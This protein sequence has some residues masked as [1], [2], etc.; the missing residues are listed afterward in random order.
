[1]PPESPPPLPPAAFSAVLA[2]MA[3]A[4]IVADAAERITY[5]NDAARRLHGGVDGLGV[6]VEAA[7]AV[8]GVRTMDG[9]PYAPAEFPLARAIRGEAVV[10]AR[11]R[12]RRADGSEVVAQGSATPLQGT[13][14]EPAGAV[15]V[16]R[17][18]TAEH[19]ARAAADAASRAKSQFLA[20]TSHEIRTP[21]NAIIGYSE[22]LELGIPGPLTDEQ[23]AYLERV[24]LSSRHLLGV[25]NQVLDLSK[26]EAGR[27]VI[28]V[29]PA[30]AGE[31]A[32]AAAA[33]VAPQAQAGRVALTNA[34]AADAAIAFLGDAGRVEQI[35]VN[36]LTNAVKFTEPGGTVTVTCGQT[37]VPAA[38]AVVEPHDRGWMYYRVEDTGVGIPPDQLETVFEPFVQADQGHTRTR[39]GTGL[40]L[41]ISRRLARMMGG[42][43]TARSTPAGGST[44]FVWLPAA[45]PEEVA[46][47]AAPAGERRGRSRY[48]RGLSVVG[49]AA[50]E[51]IERVLSG[52]AARL[53]S[54][55]ATPSARA[56]DDVD[57]EDHTATFLA[58][59]AQALAAIEAA[60]GEPSANLRDGTLIQR[61][62]AERHGSQRARLGWSEAE[63]RREFEVLRE[64]LAHAVRRRVRDADGV[65]LEEALGLFARF[66]A[67][68]EAASRRTM[69]V[70]AI[71]PSAAPEA[72]P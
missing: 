62:I 5:V 1:M 68:A 29:R 44:F 36:L 49:E 55:P 10:D 11:W 58:D 51:E 43:V 72:T 39:E 24:R 48:A 67:H 54:D 28:R 16:L 22:L 57:L 64:E 70:T 41:A 30:R 3:D 63:L 18:A 61:V 21:I 23:R 42:D 38:D 15:L 47:G 12:I 6:P 52:Y 35:L 60:H 4:V 59:M 37:R 45:R 56:M 17:D 26:I 33:L 25:V 53:R 8:Y 46:G 14:G 40:G 34:C 13:A 9:E 50:L 71:L 32:E 69:A 65:E 27:M 20:T 66:I 19:D 2:Q 31:P 7:S